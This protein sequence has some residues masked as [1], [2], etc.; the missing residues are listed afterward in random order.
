MPLPRSSK[1]ICRRT[2]S[3]R[4]LWPV[5]LVGPGRRGRI[6]EIRHVAG[7]AGIERVDHHLAVD[8]AG[9]LDRGGRAGPWAAAPPSSRRRGSARSLS[10][11]PAS[12]RHRAASAAPCAA[13][14][15]RRR[16][17][18]NL[19]SSSTRK[20]SA[21]GVRICWK[22]GLGQR[23][24][25]KHRA[26]SRQISPIQRSRCSS[27]DLVAILILGMP[28]HDQEIRTLVEGDQRMMPHAAAIIDALPRHGLESR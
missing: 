2:A 10:G 24:N 17:G 16:S 5:E 8:R 15:R 25:R 12:R 4:L 22:C 28:V 1:V 14:S 19:R 11:S 27:D 6:L 26:M 13:S 7:G 20:A 18:P 23:G 21:S 3:I 9:D